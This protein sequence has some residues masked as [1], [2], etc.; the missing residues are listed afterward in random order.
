MEANS[1]AI[2]ADDLPQTPTKKPD[3]YQAGQARCA[4][5]AS[6]HL[7]GARSDAVNQ[8]TW[9]SCALAEARPFSWNSLPMFSPSAWMKITSWIPMKLMAWRR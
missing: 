8:A 9:A 4:H 2:E 3:L 7:E 5:G 1:F 6:A